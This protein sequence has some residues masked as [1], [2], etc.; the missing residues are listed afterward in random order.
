MHCTLTKCRISESCSTLFLLFLRFHKTLNSELP[1]QHPS[2][3]NFMDAIRKTVVGNG[4]SVVAQIQGARFSKRK[5]DR[6][7]LELLRKAE[8][9]EQDYLAGILTAKDVLT[10]VAAHYVDEN[11]IIVMSHY[12]EEREGQEDDEP[13]AV[14]PTEGEFNQTLFYLCL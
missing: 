3:F 12:A 14:D 11:L 10:Q 9:V 13:A 2:I 6:V 8:D 4:I 5:H 7:Q 1:S